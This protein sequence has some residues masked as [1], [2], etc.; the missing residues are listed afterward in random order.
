MN[1]PLDMLKTGSETCWRSLDA[2]VGNCPLAVARESA[3]MMHELTGDAW[4]SVDLQ[5]EATAILAVRTWLG[6]GYAPWEG[7]ARAEIL[8]NHGDEYLFLVQ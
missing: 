2:R 5:V 4:Q 6:T 8:N 1:P 7:W 3:K